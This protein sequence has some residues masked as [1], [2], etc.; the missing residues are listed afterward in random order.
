[1]AEEI[2]HCYVKWAEAVT[3][4]CFRVKNHGTFA[5]LRKSFH[6]PLAIKK[7]IME[8]LFCKIIKIR[9][10][11]YSLF[12]STYKQKS[13]F[14]Y[15]YIRIFPRTISF[16]SFF[17][18]LFYILIQ[19]SIMPNSKNRCCTFFYQNAITIWNCRPA[20]VWLIRMQ[21]CAQHMFSQD[22]DADDD[23][24]RKSKWWGL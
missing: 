23:A 10:L 21:L 18:I 16:H 2:C 5:F 7:A 17:C 6:F 24:L 3:T 22:D 8:I 1:M 9:I 15:I 4:E 12:S 11:Y 13:L 20:F 19:Y 14:T